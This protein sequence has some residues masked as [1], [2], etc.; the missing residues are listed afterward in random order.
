MAREIECK[1]ESSSVLNPGSQSCLSYGKNS[2][3]AR[4]RNLFGMDGMIARYGW[5]VLCVEFHAKD[6]RSPGFWRQSRMSHREI[7][8]DLV[9]PGEIACVI[10][11]NKRSK[12]ILS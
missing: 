3:I 9:N 6:A 10:D 12:N 4:S 7:E 8:S 1:V 2:R 5:N 11:T